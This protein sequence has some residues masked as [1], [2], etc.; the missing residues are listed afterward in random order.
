MLGQSDTGDGVAYNASPFAEVVIAPIM[1]LSPTPALTV[2]EQ[3]QTV[4]YICKLEHRVPFEGEATAMLYG[5]PPDFVIT[6]VN[7]TKATTDLIFQIPAKPETAVTKHSNL[8]EQC[9]V[10]TPTGPLLQRLA[11][12][13]VLRVDAPPKA[14]PPPAAPAPVVAATPA[15]PPPPKVLTRLEQLRAKQLAPK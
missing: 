12:A 11:F 1:V 4:P 13:G 3:G 6:P 14:A 2:V 9:S 10:P 7:F 15:A 5:L 8:F